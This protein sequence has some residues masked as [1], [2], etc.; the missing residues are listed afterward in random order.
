MKPRN[1]ASLFVVGVV[2]LVTLSVAAVAADAGATGTTTTYFACLASTGTLSHVGTTRPS[3]TECK[4]PSEVISWDSLGAVGPQGPAGPTG[5]QG[6]AGA[7]GAQG[8]TGATGATGAQ[9]SQGPSGYTNYDLAQENGY[10]GSL[11]QW[12]TSLVGPQGPSGAT[13]PAGGIGPQG[14][15]GPQGPVGPAGTAGLFGTDDNSFSAAS[16]AGAQCTIGD[17]QLTASTEIA[18][19]WL[20][21]KGQTLTFANYGPLG[22]LVGDNYGGNGSTTFDLPNLTAAAPDGLTYVICVAGVFP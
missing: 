19:N 5:G 10:E 12:L 1:T 13:G 18:T 7:T 16:G 2:G 14:A 11:T 3:A 8:P 15:A 21:A 17:V 22:S 4:S 6:P 20:P 9:G